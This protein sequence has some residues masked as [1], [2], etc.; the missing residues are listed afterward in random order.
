[1]L[2]RTAMLVDDKKDVV[3]VKGGENGTL[4]IEDEKFDIVSGKTEIPKVPEMIGYVRAVYTDVN[5][6]RYTV[7]KPHIKNQTPY[8]VIESTSA[9]VELL[10]EN[11]KQARQI[12]R[13]NEEIRE[14]RAMIKPRGLGHLK[15]GG[16]KNEKAE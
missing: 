4:T 3:T 16:Q 10:I 6:I 7:R 15:I 8:T 11:D 5:G 13:L 12:E 14:L 2:N 9:C 1:M